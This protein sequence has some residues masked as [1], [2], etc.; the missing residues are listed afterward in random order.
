MIEACRRR[1][2]TT[3]EFAQRIVKGKAQQFLLA[4]ADDYERAAEAL[5]RGEKINGRILD[6]LNEDIRKG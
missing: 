4:L 3:R 2:A 6:Y 5:E 1:A